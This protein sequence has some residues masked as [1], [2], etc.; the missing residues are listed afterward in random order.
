MSKGVKEI[1]LI[2]QDLTDYGRDLTGKRGLADL[3]RNLSDVD[4]L[5][6]LRLMYAFPSK[7]PTD[8]LPVIAERSNICTY[9]DMPLQHASTN[10]L[11]SMRRGITRNTT[12]KLLQEIRETVPG[13][14]LRTTFIA[15]YPSETEADF[16]ELCDFVQEQRFDRVGV[17]EY[18]QED[19]TYSFI[20]GDPI[21][22]EV[23]QERTARLMEIQREI[24]LEKNE[25]KVGKQLKILIDQ[26]FTDENGAIEY[27]GRSEADAPEVDNEVFL[28]SAKPLQTG[29]FVLADI[30]DA[31]EY[32]LFGD[33]VEVLG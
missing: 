32:D 12:E 19:D 1:V 18:S 33:V 13:I 28:K 4:G 6:W 25:A 27:Q 24:S 3:L 17:F 2:A 11:K 23:K 5:Q 29:D 20:L 14:A 8:I 16:Q 7:F 30:T 31:S 10:V 26:S 22:A 9:L 15:G 21:P